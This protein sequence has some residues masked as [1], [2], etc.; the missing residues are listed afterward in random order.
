MDKEFVDTCY[1][2]GKKVGQQ[3]VVA[4]IRHEFATPELHSLSQS[5][6]DKLLSIFNKMEKRFPPLIIGL[7][8]S[9][10]SIAQSPINFD[11]LVPISFTACGITYVQGGNE[12]YDFFKE[13]PLIRDS[14]MDI[15]GDGLCSLDDADAALTDYYDSYITTIPSHLFIHNGDIWFNDSTSEWVT[16]YTILPEESFCIQSWMLPCSVVICWIP[17]SEVTVRYTMTRVSV[18]TSIGVFV[19]GRRDNL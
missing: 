13:I 17:D 16:S 2:S 8:M 10:L 18:D 11:K 3:E 7:M 1:N 4:F 9:L 6:K 19:Y 15:T 14:D 5:F 12:T